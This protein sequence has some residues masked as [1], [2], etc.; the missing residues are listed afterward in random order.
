VTQQ[1]SETNQVPETDQDTLATMLREWVFWLWSWP[2]VDR[3]QLL[4]LVC[5]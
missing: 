2:A 3:G 4:I 5:G 1:V